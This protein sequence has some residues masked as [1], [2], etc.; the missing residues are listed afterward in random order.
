MIWFVWA[1]K[2]TKYFKNAAIA[3]ASDSPPM[4]RVLFGI[5]FNLT[6]RFYTFKSHACM[7]TNSRD[8]LLAGG[9]EMCGIHND[10]F[11][12]IVS[13]WGSVRSRRRSFSFSTPLTPRL[14]NFETWSLWN[15]MSRVPF[16]FQ[17]FKISNSLND[18]KSM[19]PP[20]QKMSSSIGC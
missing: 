13:R 17:E 2:Y 15:G 5:L 3:T 19:K 1:N 4:K 6:H 10:R 18:Y 14:E 16:N 9:G 8:D 20:R 11:S 7:R 12:T